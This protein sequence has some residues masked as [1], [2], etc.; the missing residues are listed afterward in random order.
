[1][2]A[3]PPGIGARSTTVTL[4]PAPARCSAADNPP[5]P[6][7]TTTTDSVDP[8]TVRIASGRYRRA[9]EAD[10]AA[11][12]PLRGGVQID[13]RLRLVGTFVGTDADPRRLAAVR[14]EEDDREHHDDDDRTIE[15][16]G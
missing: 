14:Q 13:G 1:M 7:P 11:G 10:C 16:A 12:R 8:G 2:P 9:Q 5:R 15:Q 6:A 3:R 4:R